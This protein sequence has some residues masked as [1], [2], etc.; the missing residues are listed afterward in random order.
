M[1]ETEELAR[2]IRLSLC[3][4][5]T[6]KLSKSMFRAITNTRIPRHGWEPKRY[7]IEE[8]VERIQGYL[9]QMRESVLQDLE[10]TPYMYL[11]QQLDLFEYSNGHLL[12]VNCVLLPSDKRPG[13]ITF[14]GRVRLDDLNPE[15]FLLCLPDED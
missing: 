15:T 12:H 2:Q 5:Q 13:S 8:T 1:L 7:S 10:D 14:G 4:L 11:R 3:H 9:T 6:K